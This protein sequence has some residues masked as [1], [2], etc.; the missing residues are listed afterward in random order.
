MALAARLGLLAVLWAT[1]VEGHPEGLAVG[2]LALPLAF[3]ASLAVEPP[4]VP[5]VRPLELVRFLPV[6][7]WRALVGSFD[8]ARRALHPRLRIAPGLLEVRSRLPVGP[9]RLFLGSVVSLVPGTVAVEVEA[10]R[11]T[12][13]LLDASPEARASALE[14]LRYLERQVARVFGLPPPP[15]GLS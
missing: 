10:D 6:L 1:L 13:H 4:G 12:L 11:L 5:Y 9:A 8:V 7:G 3:W 15:R 14:E 2:L